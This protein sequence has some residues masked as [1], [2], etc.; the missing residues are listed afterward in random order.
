M[1]RERLRRVTW[2]Y[3]T[4]PRCKMKNSC[5]YVWNV[6]YDF[7]VF[8]VGCIRNSPGL[9]SLNFYYFSLHQFTLYENQKKKQSVSLNLK[10]SGVIWRQLATNERCKCFLI[11]R[12]CVYFL[13]FNL[14]GNNPPTL[15]FLKNILKSSLA[16]RK[17][18]ECPVG[19]KKG[20]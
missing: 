4:S 1:G 16:P 17:S 5:V 13:Q 12:I 11:I 2:K 18:R 9:F 10:K 8:C 14:N 20:E 7:D 19:Y 6:I 3:L 15:I